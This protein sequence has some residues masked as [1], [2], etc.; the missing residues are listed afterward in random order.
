MSDLTSHVPGNVMNTACARW[1]P[2][3]R[4]RT[5]APWIPLRAQ[6]SFGRARLRR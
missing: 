5:L 4:D 2:G 1:M 6:A 3:Q